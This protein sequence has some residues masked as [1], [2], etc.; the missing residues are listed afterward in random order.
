MIADSMTKSLSA[1]I[2]EKLRTE[3]G[4]DNATDL[5]QEGVLEN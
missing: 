5:Q 3:M 2:K 4:L 1:P